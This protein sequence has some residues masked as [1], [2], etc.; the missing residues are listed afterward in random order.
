MK[1]R[2][3]QAGFV[4]GVRF[5]KGS[6]NTGTHVG[7]L[8]SVTG[9]LLASATFTNESASG[10]Q[11]ATFPALRRDLGEHH[12]RGLV[13]QR[14]GFYAFDSGFFA[15]AGVDD[16]PL[17]A[18]QDGDRPRQRASTLR[19]H[20]GL[21]NNSFNSIELLGRC[22]LRPKL[23]ADTTPPTLTARRPRPARRGWPCS[24]P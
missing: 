9:T 8:W 2:S 22:G 18:L 1:F 21:P 6:G 15:T 4:K 5:Y 17:H 16:P 3:D 23:A 12:L 11:E 14:H 10:W 24:S 13:S 7:S 19:R 20:H